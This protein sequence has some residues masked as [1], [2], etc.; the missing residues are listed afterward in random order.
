MS[1]NKRIITGILALTICGALAGCANS[2]S[3]SDGNSAETTADSAETTAAAD[4][5]EPTEAP[6]LGAVAPDSELET[7]KTDLSTTIVWNNA[8]ELH[9]YIKL[10][11][12]EMISQKTTYA[13]LLNTTWEPK[14]DY[15]SEPIKKADSF[16]STVISG[17]DFKSS[18]NSGFVTFSVAS[19]D[20]TVDS[21]V[22]EGVLY[23]MKINS[24]ITGVELPGG[25]T[26]DSTIDEVKAVLG[27]PYREVIWS[28]PAS[29]VLAYRLDSD[30]VMHLTFGENSEM[31]NVDFNN[32]YL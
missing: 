29:T 24:H 12:I 20:Y 15:S 7:N 31:Y 25:L 23:D 3:S 28:D 9:S 30:F 17:L 8:P 2:S 11:G 6:N 27:T 5:A 14:S 1:F 13:D 4:S 21:T 19:S 18:S 10:D 16:F 26:M 32:S 22:G